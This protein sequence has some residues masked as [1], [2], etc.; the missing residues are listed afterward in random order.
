MH[1]PYKFEIV[2]LMQKKLCYISY[3]SSKSH[4]A[5]RH[6]F[7]TACNNE[8]DGDLGSIARLFITFSTCLIVFTSFE[9]LYSHKHLVCHNF[10]VMFQLFQQEV[11]WK[12]RFK[13]FFGKNN[14]R[15]IL[16]M[17]SY[18]YSGIITCFCREQCG[19]GC[20]KIVK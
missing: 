13:I 9:T 5:V 2:R 17:I 12:N 7:G 10:E 19:K 14:E 15:S 16:I 6:I 4:N 18:T 1:M 3:H 20:G 8:Q 11:F